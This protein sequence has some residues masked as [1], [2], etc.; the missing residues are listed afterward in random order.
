M[1]H[2]RSQAIGWALS[3][4]ISLSLLSGASTAVANEYELFSI[5]TDGLAHPVA[6]YDA[7]VSSL[8]KGDVVRFTD[9]KSYRLTANLHDGQGSV[10]RIFSVKAPAGAALRLPRKSNPLFVEM[11]NRSIDGSKALAEAGVPVVSIQGSKRG[12]YLLVDQIK[13]GLIKADAFFREPDQV[14]RSVRKKMVSRLIEFAS[15]TAYF[16]HIGDFGLSQMAYDAF[17]DRWVLLDWTAGHEIP[18]SQADSKNCFEHVFEPVLKNQNPS[19]KK[20]I[21]S[22]RGKIDQ[23]I[24]EERQKI[25][26][27]PFLLE[28][29]KRVEE[30]VV[31]TP[32]ASQASFMNCM[33]F[34]MSHSIEF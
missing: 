6:D 29:L 32:R 8:K 21:E 19:R 22:I 2:F 28:R 14:S 17:S 25:Q 11:I 23:A 20:W 10:S 24:R 12:E 33:I 1:L 15:T 30:Q 9:G 27:D 26:S 7:I 16:K 4:F 31:R 34:N 5:G 3:F 18:A 13:P